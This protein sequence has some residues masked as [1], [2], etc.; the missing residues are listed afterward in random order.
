MIDVLYVAYNRLAYTRESFTA[1]LRNT[2]WSEVE[3]LYVFDDAST[4]GTA[5]WLE[6]AVLDHADGGVLADTY[7]RM[8]WARKGGPVAAMNWYLDERRD[9]EDATTEMFAKVD[10]DFVVCPGWL[11]EMI[12]QMTLHPELDLLGTEPFV[13]DPTPA[14]YGD[15][16]ITTARHIGGKGLIRLRAFRQCRPSPG[17]FNGYQGFTQWQE[18]HEQVSKAWITPDLLCFGLDQMREGPYRD[19]A[20]VYAGLDWMRMWPVYGG[21]DHYSWWKPA[22]EDVPQP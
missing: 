13:G 10:N 17:G 7:Y 22:F 18:Q 3:S 4:D 15:R 14:P 11:R 1:L 9:S 5:E 21:D 2:D 16:T 12:R 6:A 20:P 19:L 8:S